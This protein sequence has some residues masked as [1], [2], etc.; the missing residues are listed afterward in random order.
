MK[1]IRLLLIFLAFFLISC[2]EI[3]QIKDIEIVKRSQMDLGLGSAYVIG[4]LVKEITGIKGKAKW[5]SFKPS[6]YED[7]PDVSCVQVDILRN[8]ERDNLV[9]IQFL[10]NRETGEVKTEYI[11][12]DK[13]EKSI[14]DFYIFIAAVGVGIN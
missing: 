10:L 7:Y 2:N 13:K 11:S 9:I 14:F 4:D 5:I 6:G 12:I 1:K 3:I 8:K